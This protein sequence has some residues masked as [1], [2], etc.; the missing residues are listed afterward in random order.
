MNMPIHATAF[1]NA[2]PIAQPLRRN[3]AEH[4]FDLHPMLHVGLF[5]GFFAY[6]GLMWAAFGEKQLAIPFAIFAIFLA[7]AY[8]V[9]AWWAWVVPDEG[10]RKPEWAEFMHEGFA[11]ETGWQSAQG[12][13]V[14]VLIMPAV[15]IG[16]GL[17]LLVVS[18]LV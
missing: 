11:C 16:W 4:V 2:Q 18:R 15:L 9:P 7:G 6:L 14:Q 13:M 12:V 8:I 5:A 17:F 3:R 10:G 1:A